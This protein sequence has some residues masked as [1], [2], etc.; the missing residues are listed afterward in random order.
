MFVHS[1][2]MATILSVAA[3]EAFEQDASAEEIR[4]EDRQLVA[5]ARAS[6]LSLDLEKLSPEIQN[7]LLALE[8]ELEDYDLPR[9]ALMS[10][11]DSSEWAM[12]E[13]SAGPTP[14]FIGVTKSEATLRE[15]PDRQAPI[16]ASIPAG[17][18]IL[19][20]LEDGDYY[21]VGVTGSSVS[22]YLYGDFVKKAELHGH[23]EG[24]IPYEPGALAEGSEDRGELFAEGVDNLA[25]VVESDRAEFKQP[26]FQCRNE[27]NLCR[28]ENFG[29]LDCELI[30]IVC[31]ADVLR[32]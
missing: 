1:I 2:L 24:L 4:L 9:E 27:L 7:V 11:M 6:I 28:R 22:G 20:L 13:P 21:Q 15:E 32:N 18:E 12:I 10:P 14:F 31:V 3:A 30:M 25:D 8:R 23:P 29:Y 19:I 17:T 5:E 16:I 26:A